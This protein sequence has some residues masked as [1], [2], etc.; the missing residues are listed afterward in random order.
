MVTPFWWSVE[1]SVRVCWAAHTNERSAG[2]TKADNLCELAV[3][4]PAEKTHTHTYIHT[5]TRNTLK[6]QITHQNIFAQKKM[7]LIKYELKYFDKI[8]IYTNK[9]AMK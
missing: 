8:K 5:H 4:F 6:K 3:C 7:Y 2:V 1:R 9:S